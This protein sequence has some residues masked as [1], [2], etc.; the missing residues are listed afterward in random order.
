MGFFSKKQLVC[1]RCGKTYEARIAVGKKLCKEC[2]D[3]L[4]QK[5]AKVVG[6]RNYLMD[7]KSQYDLTEDELD[8]INLHRQ[9]I[10]DKYKINDGTTLAQLTTKIDNYETLTDEQADEVLT[11]LL[12]RVVDQSICS[13]TSNHFILPCKYPGTIVDNDDVYAASYSTVM[14]LSGDNREA[15]LCCCFTNDPYIPVV[16]MLFFGKV[17]FFEFSSKKG[18]E[19]VSTLMQLMFP[20][21]QYP[22]TSSKELKKIIKKED[23]TKGQLSKEEMLK[24]LDD[25]Q[26]NSGMFKKKALSEDADV[27]EEIIRFINDMDYITDTQASGILKLDRV[28]FGT[29]WKKKLKE[30]N[31]KLGL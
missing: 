8:A 17:G 5:E 14:G 22:I 16:P 11:Q 3:I 7:V 30:Y 25:A 23:S 2:S 31:K 20:N 29:F 27:T 21:L 18:R 13:C 15:I 4:S 28:I 9:K 6:Y 12:D 10:I 26:Y 19:G 1:E 24:F